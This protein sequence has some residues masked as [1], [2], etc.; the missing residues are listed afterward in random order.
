MTGTFSDPKIGVDAAPLARAA[1]GGAARDAL[2]RI[3]I[4]T[5]EGASVEDTVREG[6]RQGLGRILGGGRD[7]PSDGEEDTGEAGEG[8]EAAAP[9]A[10]DELIERGLGAVF[11][12]RRQT[13][14]PPAEDAPEE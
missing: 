14:E 3:G 6:A 9:S 5:E 2:G 4:E 1:A 8:E 11:G 7:A 13:E 10:R 12:G